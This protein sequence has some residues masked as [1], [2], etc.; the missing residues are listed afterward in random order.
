MSL[1]RF[2]SLV[3]LSLSLGACQTAWWQGHKINPLAIPQPLREPLQ[4]DLSSSTVLESNTETT[5]L[6][7]EFSKIPPMLIGRTVVDGDEQLELPQFPTHEAVTLNID[8]MPLP[9][10]INEVFGNTLQLSF[11]ISAELEKKID[12]VS[13][14][15]SQA[16]SPS[17][18]Y[19]TVLQVLQEYGVEVVSKGKILHIIVND[20][21][22]AFGTEGLP[23]LIKGSALP[24]VPASHRPVFQYVLLK[25]V[26][27]TQVAGWMR[28]IYKSPKLKIE[29]DPE[30]NAIILIGPPHLVK[31]ARQGLEF[32]DSTFMR[33]R[34]GIRIEPSF[35]DVAQL[36]KQLE[37]VLRTEGYAVGNSPRGQSSVIL[38]SMPESN[39]LVA[40]AV[41]PLVLGH[42]RD[43][44][45]TLDKPKMTQ[46]SKGLFF[47]PVKHVPASELF[48]VIAPLLGTV[49]ELNTPKVNK[50]T[51]DKKTRASKIRQTNQAGQQIVVDSIRNA[52]LFQGKAEEWARLLPILKAMDIPPKQLLIEV[53]IAEITLTDNE[54]FGIEWASKG[55]NL[56]TGLAETGMR[57]GAS[58]LS[59]SLVNALGQTRAIL[60]VLASNSRI[61]V[62][63]SPRL[64]VKS[65]E[66]A[67][68]TIG[69]QVPILTS[70]SSDPNGQSAGSSNVLRQI[71]YL[72]TGTNLSVTPTVH[73]GNRIDID[74]SQSVSNALP[75]TSSGIDSPTINNR[76]INTKLSLT[77]G[78]SVLLGGLIESNTSNS[79]SGV[80]FFKDIPILGQFFGTKGNNTVRRE[81]IIL[82]VPYVLHDEQQMQEITNLYRN[83]LQIEMPQTFRNPLL[84]MLEGF[85]P[86]SKPKTPRQG[87]VDA[88]PAQ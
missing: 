38:L 62:L 87:N 28:R 46:D 63:S 36:Y 17:E 5:Q 53:T 25:V 7:P 15:I 74:I 85:N 21:K 4:D 55:I 19:R 27:N 52:L 86:D 30:R 44:V 54:S 64:M 3:T 14:R 22:N 18:L 47:F 24:E 41:D 9:A 77:D 75:N 67:S 72:T 81:L 69:D 23:L 20:K 49:T 10:F 88:K 82:I 42:I 60:S 8:G 11:K 50:K 76:S 39:A 29:E 61:N 43:W 48:D 2:L 32:F 33:G 58:G 40:F 26:K 45:E 37:S 56:G 68:I 12:L 65:G 70:E 59:Y 1:L 31:Q 16:Q 6:S 35:L 34:Y 57:V 78:G 51:K 71:Q 79:N 66:T 80:P 13:L 84:P 83:S 73:A